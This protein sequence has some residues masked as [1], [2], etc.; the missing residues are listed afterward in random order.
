MYPKE[1]PLLVWRPA[2]WL[3]CLVPSRMLCLMPSSSSGTMIMI[4]HASALNV[5]ILAFWTIDHW[6]WRIHQSFYCHITDLKYLKNL[7]LNL[8]SSALN[9]EWM[10]SIQN[11]ARQSAQ[12]LMPWH[13]CPIFKFVRTLLSL[14]WFIDD[15]ETYTEQML[16]EH[17]YFNTAW[18]PAEP[19]I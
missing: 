4:S 1:P 14:N 6:I 17:L 18:F 3:L 15:R 10:I 8:K 5:E 13:Y 16:E 12:T 19:K 11:Q 7:I 9:T 2:S